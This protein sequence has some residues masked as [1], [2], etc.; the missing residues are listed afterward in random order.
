M[1]ASATGDVESI[2]TQRRKRFVR[3]TV[4]VAL[5]L[6][7]SLVM[8]AVVF[9]SD[10]PN[11]VAVTIIDTDVGT[12][13]FDRLVEYGDGGHGALASI[14][15]GDVGVGLGIGSGG[16]GYRPNVTIWIY[17]DDLD[18]E[19]AR[20]AIMQAI[21]A[22]TV[23]VVTSGDCLIACDGTGQSP[24]APTPP[25]PEPE[26]IPEPDTEQVAPSEPAPSQESEPTAEP[27]VITAGTASAVSATNV[28]QVK[29]KKSAKPLRG[30]ARKCLT[31]SSPSPMV[32]SP[33]KGDSNERKHQAT[34]GAG[35]CEGSRQPQADACRQG[36][37]RS[38]RDDCECGSAGICTHRGGLLMQPVTSEGQVRRQH[39]HHR[40]RQLH[41]QRASCD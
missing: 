27:S 17:G 22:Q 4:V 2:I 15:G 33:T 10:E 40:L 14:I 35:S 18:A 34:K 6:A 29:R 13:A 30:K 25:Q 7:V 26:P 20:T 16:L 38:R 24:V 1:N 19:S 11:R 36:G 41:R 12:E 32:V 8:P 39:L 5:A 28:Q 9:A 3:A 31:L 37:N 21:G 23:P